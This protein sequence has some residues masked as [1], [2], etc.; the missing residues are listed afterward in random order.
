MPHRISESINGSADSPIIRDSISLFGNRGPVALRL[1]VIPFPPMRPI[2]NDSALPTVSLGALFI[3][4][5]GLFGCSLEPLPSAAEPRRLP[6]M[7]TIET[8]TSPR[9]SLP[10]ATEDEIIATATREALANDIIAAARTLD[11]TGDTPTRTRL[12]TTVAAAVAQQNPEIAARLA[13]A[14]PEGA[15]KSSAAEIAAQAWVQRDPNAAL[16]WAVSAPDPDAAI[17]LRRAVAM[18]L[19]RHHPS[20]ILECLKALPASRGRDEML[21][22]AAAAWSRHDIDATVAWLRSQPDDPLR[23]RLIA[24]V[25]FEI[26]QRSPDQAIALAE[27]LPAGRDR[28][29]VFSTIAQTWIAKDPKAAVT[30]ATQLPPGDAREA[31]LAGVNSGMGLGSSR[32]PSLVRGTPPREASVATTLPSDANANSSVL[33]PELD[34]PAFAAWLATQPQ[35][36]SRDEAILEFVRQRGSADMGS[37]GNWVA[38]LAGEPSRQRAMEIYLDQTVRT[39]PAGAADWLRSLPASSRS[40]DMI[41]KTARELSHTDPRAAEALLR[42]TNFPPHRQEEILRNAPR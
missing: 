14:L 16:G 35:A 4:C 10:A 21:G 5:L 33:R 6:P 31:A 39:S 29:L 15:G 32:V 3:G 27:S 9:P 37:I 2:R 8:R 25:A 41:E 17:A 23:Q 7:P 12:G 11:V 1:H 34:S 19:I 20:A 22:I 26:A 42:D 30:W 18:E 28:W 38:G 40:D 24:N 13:L 36:M